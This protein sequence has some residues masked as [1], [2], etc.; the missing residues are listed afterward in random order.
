MS[1]PARANIG[2]I[3]IKLGLENYEHLERPD[4]EITHFPGQNFRI[5]EVSS[6]NPCHLA[7]G[8]EPELSQQLK[9]LHIPFTYWLN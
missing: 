3:I 7:S 4:S 1:A 5:Q 6:A 9:S 2:R 8:R